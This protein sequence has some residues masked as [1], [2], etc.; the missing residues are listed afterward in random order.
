MSS[1]LAR[2]RET[3]LGFPLG[4]S[5]R[6]RATD[7]GI[8]ELMN[9]L[10]RLSRANATSS[11]GRCRHLPLQGKACIYTTSANNP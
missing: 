5:C 9:V 4:G 6:P 8:I 1:I 3:S 2:K 10:D 7:E 11:V